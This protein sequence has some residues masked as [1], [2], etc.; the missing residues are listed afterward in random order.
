MKK[1]VLDIS[2]KSVA[3]TGRGNGQAIGREQLVGKITKK[4]LP[5]IICFPSHITT[6]GSS[7]VEGIEDILIDEIKLTPEEVRY[8]VGYESSDESIN[9]E[10]D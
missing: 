9:K 10:I 7:Y 1:I 5:I 4:D 6:V 2:V 8:K 3:V